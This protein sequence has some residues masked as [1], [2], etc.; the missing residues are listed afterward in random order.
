[1]FAE[2]GSNRL[3]LYTGGY[4]RLIKYQNRKLY[5]PETSS[6]VTYKNIANAI[7]EG[8]EITVLDHKTKQDI[9]NETFARIIGD[10]KQ[11]AY[12]LDRNELKAMITKLQLTGELNGE[13]TV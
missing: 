2:L 5:Y 10:H 8:T 11:K 3:L 12:R 9:T 7:G 1:M 6:Y 4:L 13:R